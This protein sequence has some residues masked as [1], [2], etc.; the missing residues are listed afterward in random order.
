MSFYLN[1]RWTWD[2]VRIDLYHTTNSGTSIGLKSKDG[3]VNRE[4]DDK[5]WDVKGVET[6]TLLC[7]W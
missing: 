7:L 1:P 3:K 6:S 5:D 2:S 4:L